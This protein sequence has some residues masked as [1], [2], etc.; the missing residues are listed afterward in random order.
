[1]HEQTAM[2]QDKSHIKIRLSQLSGA[3]QMTVLAKRSKAYW[4][5]KPAL[6]IVARAVNCN[7]G[8]S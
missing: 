8:V 4:G 7:R 1:M 5:Y 3:K 2:E 6:Q